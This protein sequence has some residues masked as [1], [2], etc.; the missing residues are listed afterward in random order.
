MAGC[1]GALL[2][3]AAVGY[4]RA[5]WQTEFMTP[6]QSAALTS[7][8]DELTE[9]WQKGAASPFGTRAWLGSE[10]L[11]VRVYARVGSRFLG[12]AVGRRPMLTLATIE[13]SPRWQ[14]QGF[15][16]A[17]LDAAKQQATPAGYG[18]FIESVMAPK[19]A[20]FLVRQGFQ[21]MATCAYDLYWLP[22]P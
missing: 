22:Q 15:F 6:L 7:I 11:G 2:T 9:L 16:T 1:K 5:M 10:S 21:S 17:L 12:H 20:A 8:L 19:F 18:L 14:F 4:Y 3:A 13:V